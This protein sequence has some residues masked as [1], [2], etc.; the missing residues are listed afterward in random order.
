MIPRALSHI[1]DA[2]RRLH[3]EDSTENPAWDIFISAYND[4]SRVREIF[5]DIKAVNKFWW[6]LPEYAYSSEETAQLPA[7]ISSN[8]TNEADLISNNFD[9]MSIDFSASG[10]ICI[11]ITGFMMPHIL[12]L[13]KYLRDSGVKNFDMIYTEP[14]HYALKAETR[15]TLD[16]VST[17]RPVAGFEGQ[18]HTSMAKDL[19]IVGVGYDHNP[20]GRI[21]QNKESARLAQLHCFPS[22]SADMYQESV[23]RIDRVAEGSAAQLDGQIFFSSAN[24]PYLTSLALSE[25][26]QYF[27]R[28]GGISNLYLSPLATKP[29]ALGFGL[30]YLKELEGAAAS[31]IYPFSTR[32]S[33]E[34]SKGVGRTWVYPV[35]FG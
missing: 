6:L 22:L 9:S 8:A 18:H 33:R 15:F 32:Y 1:I 13:L 29:Q 7:H 35:V 19:L 26:V 20:V 12:F 24:D 30:F 34:T 31:I 27:L 16:D 23:L 2:K 4:S 10:R 28:A 14:E 3:L 11:D 17:V 21:I 25:T 5:R